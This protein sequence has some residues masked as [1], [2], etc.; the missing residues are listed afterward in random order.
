MQVSLAGISHRTAPVAVRERFAFAAAELVPALSD[1]RDRFGGVAILSTCNRTEVYITSASLPPAADVVEALAAA[2]GVATLE[3][4]GFYDQHGAE[5]VRHLFR[6]TAGLDSLVLGEYEILGQVRAAFAAA[7]AAHS[8]NPALARLFHAAIRVGRR[9]RNETEIGRS[10]VSVASTAVALTRNALG[11]LRRRSVLI[12]GAGEAGA[13]IGR[14]LVQAGAGR[15][16]VTTRTQERAAAIASELGA[17]SLPFEERYDALAEADVAIT[18]TAAPGYV[19]ER[20]ALAAVLDRRPGRPLVL[21]DIAVPRDVDPSVASLAGVSLFDIDALQ[22]AAEAGLERRRREVG[23]VE[24]IVAEETRRFQAWLKGLGA[25]PTVK[26]ISKRAEAARQAELERTLARLPGQSATERRQ[27]E[28][29][30]KALVKRVLHDPLTRLRDE[31]AGQHHIDAAR[32]LFGL[33]EPGGSGGDR[34]DA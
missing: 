5:A 20:D 7:T 21:V 1:L 22:D 12:V 6:V 4:G 32:D 17:R 28:A 25:V 27:V 13:Q 2:R 16:L 34:T 23:A 24:R 29:M 10:Q 15:V 11:D 14:S 9:A 18:S 19:I 31:S 30:T 26:A 8:S 3:G 33:S